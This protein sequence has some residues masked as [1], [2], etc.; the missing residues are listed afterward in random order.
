M[1]GIILTDLHVDPMYQQ[2]ASPVDRCFCRASCSNTSQSWSGSLV[3]P[4]GQAGC[5]AP[6]GL[7]DLILSSA[8]REVPS[9]DF[10]FLLGDIIASRLYETSENTDAVIRERAEFYPT[11]TSRIAKAFPSAANSSHGLGCAVAL[12]N[13]D[14]YP[15]YNISLNDSSMYVRQAGA[16]AA[17]CGLSDDE[18]ASFRRGGFYARGAPGGPRLAVLNTGPYSSQHGPPLNVTLHPDPFGQ[19]AWLE[20]EL[21]RAT[22]QRTPLLILGHMPPVL[23]FKDR[24]PIWQEAYAT[25]YWALLARHRSAVAGQFFGHS[26]KAQFRVWG[27]VPAEAQAPLLVMGSVSPVYGNNPGFSVV[28]LGE[29][30][31][32]G[33]E[34]DA[35]DLR[36]SEVRAY[37]ADLAAAKDGETPRVELLYTTA[38]RLQCC[39]PPNITSCCTP[40]PQS[41]APSDAVRLTN[42]RYDQWAQ[43]MTDD[44]APSAARCV[45]RRLERPTRKPTGRDY[46]SANQR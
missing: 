36:P 40:L 15:D 4:F 25:R 35:V 23:E 21:T 12:G 17:M 41:D 29:G 39:A 3:R 11:V 44:P 6:L 20:A 18:S 45:A 38:T 28:T 30:G 34:E 37:Y 1:R 31:G 33:E 22:A 26:H 14:V 13:N 19:F 7:L 46:G 16:V 5:A 43:S 32:G 10:V 24:M 42:A 9:P 27:G 8:A 2:T